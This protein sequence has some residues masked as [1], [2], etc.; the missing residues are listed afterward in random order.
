M[1]CDVA[2]ADPAVSRAK[3]LRLYSCHTTFLHF[4]V[5]TFGRWIWE[6]SERSPVNC[7]LGI[8]QMSG[9]H[10][11]QTSRCS[12]LNS[13]SILDFSCL[14]VI[15]LFIHSTRSES[16]HPRTCSWS[17]KCFWNSHNR[18]ANRACNNYYYQDL[19]FNLR[20]PRISA[21]VAGGWVGQLISW[22][23]RKHKGR[24]RTSLHTYLFSSLLHCW[25][26]AQDHQRHSHPVWLQILN[27]PEVMEGWQQ[28]WHSG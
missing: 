11:K 19:Q 21:T 13:P 23:I 26:S 24:R 20:V 12:C 6:I 2:F 27:A 15:H 18:S 17:R 25:M 7:F 3:S 4:H 9:H 1:R 14:K 8:E 5:P 28:R 10:G 22:L 16:T